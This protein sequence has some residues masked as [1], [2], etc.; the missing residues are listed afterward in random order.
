MNASMFFKNKKEEIV[1][2][3]LNDSADN[4]TDDNAT[5]DQV[6]K[7]QYKCSPTKYSDEY[8]NYTNNRQYYRK[9]CQ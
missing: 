4:P 2:S 1:R 5:N 8:R 9:Y 6:C 7:C 3:L